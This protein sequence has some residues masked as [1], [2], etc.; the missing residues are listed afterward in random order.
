MSGRGGSDSSREEILS[1]LFR[2][3]AMVSLAAAALPAAM[4]GLPAGAF[5]EIAAAAAAAAVV[6]LI[7]IAAVRFAAGRSLG[8]RDAAGG[9]FAAA[10]PLTW[11]ACGALLG[12]ALLAAAFGAF[13]LGFAGVFLRHLAAYLAVQS[14]F[15]LALHR[16]ARGLA[17]GRSGSMRRSGDRLPGLSR[18]QGLLLALLLPAAGIAAG[19]GWAGER[20]AARATREAAAVGYSRIAAGALGTPPL[21]HAG[22]IRGLI[23]ALT[24]FDEAAPFAMSGSGAIAG[25]LDLPLRA[26]LHA[27]V[28]REPG[29]DSIDPD[30]GRGLVWTTLAPAGVVAGIRLALPADPGFGGV[31]IA[32]IL[33]AALLGALAATGLG[34]WLRSRLSIRV[35]AI[36]ALPDREVP[37]MSP[38]PIRELAGLDRA[39]G[40]GAARFAT[41]QAGPGPAALDAQGSHERQATVF[42]G[43]SHD[44]RSPLNSVVGFTDLLL[45]GMDGELEPAQRAS[46]AVIAEES[47]RLLVRIGDILDTARLDAGRFEI[48]RAWVPSVEILTECATGAERLVASKDVT[49]SSQLQP[50]LPPVRVDKSRIVQALLSLVARALEATEHGVILLE[51]RR[52]PGSRGLRVEIGDPGGAVD[53]SRRALIARAWKIAEAGWDSLGSTG[54]MAAELGPAA[55]GLSLARRMVALHGGTITAATELGDRILFALT[56]PLDSGGD[57]G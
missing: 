5:R 38:G 40:I 44:L 41:R 42:A 57:E 10:V 47:E 31:I 51:A 24:P 21:P 25:N 52:L 26:R 22:G 23:E 16:V 36:E 39:I 3:T 7:Q 56:L 35:A 46:V 37:A 19:L 34:S 49:F 13:G 30:T 18:T 12:P 14:V 50:G 17:H 15:A 9:G 11:S 1:R 2:W 55:L 43:M 33:A 45:K 4:A 48:E 29:G 28:A 53:A 6:A 20:A 54:P 32:L 8:R 27:A